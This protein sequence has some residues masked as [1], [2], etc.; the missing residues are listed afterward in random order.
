VKRLIGLLLL[1]CA[2]LNAQNISGRVEITAVDA[3]NLTSYQTFGSGI[4][5]P[6]SDGLQLQQA[7]LRTQFDLSTSWS[8]DAIFNAHED[9]EEH[10]GFTQAFLQYKPL[11]PNKIK[12]KS[13]VGFF[14]PAM[15]IENVAEGWL[16]PYTYTQSAIN[17]WIGE[18]LR[19][20]GAEFTLFSNGRARRSPWSWEAHIGVFKGND[21]LGT[22]LTWRGW[23][24]H[25][26]QSIHD[27]RVNFARIPTVIR[28]DYINAPPW[29]DPFT[30]IDGLWGGYIG[31]HLSYFRQTE[32]RYYYYD[33]HAD[34]SVVNDLR[35][36]A[37]RTKF[38]SL[39]FQ[40][41]LN[42][43]WRFMSQI[44]DGSTDM[45]PQI[46][47]ADFRSWYLALRYQQEKHSVTFRY[48]WFRVWEDDL[49]P[50]DQNDSDGY[51]VT[52]AWRYQLNSNWELGAEYHYNENNVAN[53]VQLDIPIEQNQSQSRLVIAYHF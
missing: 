37:W 14:Y 10:F 6:E 16:S 3:D 48:D 13:R 41:N 25:D 7:F 35:L 46:V 26:R 24:M 36:Y 31:V 11:S 43:R 19:T 50:N 33:N 34:Q 29:V 15:S 4:L 17:S 20:L 44:M 1:F 52:L 27:D 22:L 30:E 40:H 2:P 38:H 51:G 21:P 42:E 23:A 18:E 5:R 39:A 45:G 49:R 32:A 12:F 9:G 53:R 28:E 47:Y 8:L